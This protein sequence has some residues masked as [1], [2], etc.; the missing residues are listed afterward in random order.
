MLF[1]KFFKKEEKPLELYEELK[2][3][4]IEKKQEWEDSDPRVFC[5]DCKFYSIIPNMASDI[6]NK[7]M[8]VKIEKI[9]ASW[10][11]REHHEAVLI[12]PD[13]HPSEI[14][15]KNNCCYFKKKDMVGE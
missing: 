4:Y 11:E 5:I 14:N 12:F 1:S 13:T 3:I 9:P 6:H 2:E 10:K 7:C 8:V 15:K